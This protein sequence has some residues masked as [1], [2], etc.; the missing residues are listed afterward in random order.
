MKSLKSL[1]LKFA[2]LAMTIGVATVAHAQA[3][4]PPIV[5]AA[6]NGQTA[7]VVAYLDQGVSP[8]TRDSDGTTPLMAAAAKGH[9]EIVRTLMIRGAQKELTDA[10]G[11]TA[12]DYAIEKNAIDVIALLR[13]GS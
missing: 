4:K 12:F 1:F 11:R 6:G 5:Q 8:D 10:K 7:A 2:L 9:F 13:D 3:N